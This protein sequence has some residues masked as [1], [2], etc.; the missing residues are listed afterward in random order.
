MLNLICLNNIYSKRYNY[1]KFPFTGP[2][3]PGASLMEA[4][5]LR[6]PCGQRQ[7]PPK[8]D[9]EMVP[10]LQGDFLRSQ[11][12]ETGNFSCACKDYTALSASANNHFT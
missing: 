5:S 10:D 1:Q 8:V 9:F 3:K 12:R 11:G 2:K 7:K 4:L 6:R